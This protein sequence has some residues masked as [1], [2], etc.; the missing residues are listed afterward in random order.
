MKRNLLLTPG[1]TQLPA[2]ICQVL[3]EPIIHHRTPQFQGVLKEVTE[4]LQYVF[5]TK[6]DVLI[7]TSSGTGGMEAAVSNFLSP[8]DQVIVLEGG[9]FGER[10]TELCQ[11][12]GIKA[13]VIKVPW[14]KAGAVSDIKKILG[15]QKEI[16]ALFVTLVETSTGVTTDVRAI[17]EALS[18]TNVILVVDA[19]S[20][21]GAVELRTDEWNVDVVVAGSQKG[22][23]LPPGLAFVSVS[24]KAWAL[25]EKSTCPKY[26]FHLKAAKKAAQKT[27]TPFTPAIGIIM[28]LNESLLLIKNEG[29]E[30]L[31]ARYARLAQGT[32]AA[33]R[34]MGLS[35][36]ADPA[37]ASHAVTAIQV[38]SGID[39]EKLTKIMRDTYGVTIAG[40]QEELKGKI[41]RICQMGCVDEFDILTG[42]A[43]L[44]KVL[45]EMGHQFTLGSG[46]A[47]A[48]K[49]YNQK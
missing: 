39:G 43:C 47:A 24:P 16:K 17:G 28:A 45:H 40:G 4:G 36:Y 44:E 1:P 25:A 14:G 12:Y 48:Q 5:Q 41:V 35:L 23:M 32:R 13:H 19:I 27:D 15:A 2:R 49:I 10:W 22:L 18:G 46:L 11:M 42:I 37:C 21:L 8:H 7:L 31:W 34:A 6:N 20:G 3:G 26:Y 30:K 38:P 29:I 9:K 33:A